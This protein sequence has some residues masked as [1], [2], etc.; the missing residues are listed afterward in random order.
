MKCYGVIPARYGSTRFPGKP[1]APILGKPLLLW[2]LEQAQ[3]AKRLDRIIVA[4]DDRRIAELAKSAQ[5]EAVMTPS[6]LPTGTD[7]VWA[8]VKD[9]VDCEV[10]INIQGDEPLIAPDLLD[11]MVE[12]FLKEPEITMVTLGRPMTSEDLDSQNTAKIVLNRNQEALYF[13]RFAIPHSRPLKE[14]S[15]PLEASLKHIGLYGFRKKFL[16]EFCAFPQTL[17]EQC[18]GLEQLRALYMGAKIKVLKVDHESWGVDVPSDIAIVEKKLLQ[19]NKSSE[20]G[21]N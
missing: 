16:Q 20:T 13:S 1:L 15:F 8:A 11:L 7:R 10:V 5:V 12:P 19:R 3:K 14:G 9:R 4:T 6:E 2:V 21:R 18:E 17:L